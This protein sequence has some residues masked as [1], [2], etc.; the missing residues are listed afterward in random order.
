MKIKRLPQ[1]ILLSLLALLH[2]PFLFEA[3]WYDEAAVLANAKIVSV[4]EYF[5]GLNWLQTIPFGFFLLVKNFISFEHGVVIGRIL[6]LLFLI[7]TVILID[8]EYLARLNNQALSYVAIAILTINSF[9]LRYATDVKPYTLEMLLSVSLLI[10][11]KKNKLLMLIL[12]SFLAPMFSS[13][14]F[15]V[16]FS[17]LSIYGIKYREKKYLAP[18]SIIVL[19]MLVVSRLVPSHTKYIMSTEWFGDSSPNIFAGVRSFIGGIFWLPTAGTGWLTD[20]LSTNHSFKYELSILF[21]LIASFMIVFRQLRNNDFHVLVLS[22]VILVT[23][24]ILRFLPA[25]GR[26]IQGF[27]ILFSLLLVNSLDTFK[28]KKFQTVILSALVFASIFNNYSMKITSFTPMVTIESI[29]IKKTIYSNLETA[30][31]IQYGASRQAMIMNPNILSNSK[32]GKL[33]GCRSEI[34]YQGD[35]YYLRVDINSEVPKLNGFIYTS[36]SP[37]LGYY[38]AS[39]QLLIRQNPNAKKMLECI[40]QYR[41]PERESATR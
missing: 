16:G 11:A 8:R 35:R 32:S 41:N 25:A 6:S 28:N 29:S 3:F 18:A 30:P 37:G 38:Q 23:L 14:A 31:E 13:T 1:K 9:S 39:E 33:E 26:L 15:I 2:L 21:F 10:C 12:L 34:L 7:A 22:G 17:A 40:Y 5:H 20:D 19:M 24:N 36:I 27:A 4:S